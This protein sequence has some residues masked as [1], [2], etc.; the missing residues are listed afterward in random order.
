MHGPAR[1]TGRVAAKLAGGFDQLDAL[2]LQDESPEVVAAWQAQK[3][4]LMEFFA[5]QDAGDMHKFKEGLS[6]LTSSF[7]D[8]M[9]AGVGPQSADAAGSEGAAEMGSEVREPP[10]QTFVP[11]MAATPA[12]AVTAGM[13]ACD[14]ATPGGEGD[15]E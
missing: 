9:C 4:R 12:D 5:T 8:E 10:T 7:R 2:Y 3:E 13:A 11:T 1:R 15:S 14:I 6:K